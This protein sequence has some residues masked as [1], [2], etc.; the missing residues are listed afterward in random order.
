[1]LQLGS[2]KYG[3]ALRVLAGG[4]RAAN[5]MEYAAKHGA[6]ALPLFPTSSSSGA[7]ADTVISG[8]DSS[9][10]GVSAARTDIASNRDRADEYGGGGGSESGAA[11]RPSPDDI[12]AG[13]AE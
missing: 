7:G 2:G 10:G 8:A 1:M 9:A 3:D 11:H 6:S 5:Q 4:G 13:Q 12:A